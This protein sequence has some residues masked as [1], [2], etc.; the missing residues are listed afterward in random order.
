M[1]RSPKEIEKQIASWLKELALD[2]K[3][4]LFA[5]KGFW[6]TRSVPRLYIPSMKLVD[7]P[8]GLGFHSAFRRATAFPT[9]IA[10]G[11]SWSPELAEEFGVALA[12]EARAVGA[13]VILGP[14][15]NICRTPLN[16]RTFEYFTEDPFLNSRLAV[17]TI[18]GIQSQNV[19]A[20][21]KHYAANNQEAF[22]MKTSSEVSERALR[23]IYLPVFEAAVREADV[24][25][26]M[27]AYNGVNGVAA[28]ENR[29][30]LQ[31]R[32]RDE[33]GFSG[34]VVSDWF[35]TRRTASGASCMAAGLNL[36]MPGKGD[37]YRTKNLARE[38]AEGAFDEEQV[39]LCLT[40]LLRTLLRTT[41]ATDDTRAI[42]T[43][44]HQ[45]LARRMAEQSIT[46]LKNSGGLLPLKKNVR[47]IAVAGHRAK[48]RNCLPLFGGSA[49]VWSP[50]EITPFKG[51]REALPRGCK[52]VRDPASADVAVVIAGIGH[53]IGGDSEIKDRTDMKL[54]LAQEKLIRDTAAANPNTI[55]VL[56][57]GGPVEMDWASDV[58]AI[59]AAW[60]PGMEGGRAIADVLFGQVNP[61][62]KLPVTFPRR[63]QDCPA[64]V[65]SK[66][67]PGDGET[68]HYEEDIFVGYRHFDRAPTEVL[69][70][71]GHGLSYTSFNYSDL[72]MPL[73]WQAGEELQVSMT[74][75]NS[76]S[77]A[78]AEV[79]QL[80]I[81]PQNSKVPRPLRE[82]KGFRKVFLESGE[83]TRVTFSL[84]E[85]ALAYWN[86]EAGS[87]RVDPGSYDILLG[88]SS[89]DLR[90]H[91]RITF[92]SDIGT[93]S[94]VTGLSSF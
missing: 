39:N 22:R 54:P 91:R 7:G 65:N 46:L 10:L 71:F 41:V 85:Q 92:A 32:L 94:E 13:N 23:E 64:H 83:R 66:R 82:L 17:P 73:C 57:S 87:W 20:C 72:A 5:G 45:D 14:A 21:I 16:G 56:V 84:T 36:E 88:S 77:R 68:V 27:A 50:Y 29:D 38:F 58:Q 33:Y 49:G 79:V 81:A 9:G 70:P 69:F 67:Y 12:R 26:V 53:R 42:N 6:K 19:A 90:L 31:I 15:V 62:G 60:Y 89:R 93:S 51:I 40:P 35:A 2:E 47:Q 75:E 52:L 4:S 44:E 37:K 74:L 59:V 76:G 1:D 24:W 25:S 43:R 11:A 28:C 18:S 3:L 61:S 34:F 86:T 78:G 48:R 55:V 63:L 80:Y 8:R 30:L